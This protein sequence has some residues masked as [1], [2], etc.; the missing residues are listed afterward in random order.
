MPIFQICI[1]KRISGILSR[2]WKVL[3]V[4]ESPEA[5]SQ[6]EFVQ[7]ILE[8]CDMLNEDGLTSALEHLAL[9]AFRGR[10]AVKP[11]IDEEHGLVLKKLENWNVLEHANKLYWNPDAD[12]RF[13]PLEEH[14][15]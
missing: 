3:P 4:D 12:D 15:S 11:F 10:A 7:N 6:A 14:L 1:N 5:K 8:K 2:K 9:A 13:L